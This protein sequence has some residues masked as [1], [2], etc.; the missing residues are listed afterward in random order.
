VKGFLATTIEF[1]VYFFAMVG[2][3]TMLGLMHGSLKY[4]QGVSDPFKNYDR[5]ES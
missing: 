3:L 4:Y 2:I 1:L 5:F